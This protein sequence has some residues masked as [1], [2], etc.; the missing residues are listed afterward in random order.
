MRDAHWSL[1]PPHLFIILY[2]L[3]RA[4]LVSNLSTSG[5][6]TWR[7]STAVGKEKRHDKWRSAQYI[8]WGVRE[9]KGRGGGK[10]VDL[11][12]C[13]FLG[14]ASSPLSGLGFFIVTLL[15]SFPY[16]TVEHCNGG[17]QLARAN[18][19]SAGARRRGSHALPRLWGGVESRHR[20][21]SRTIVVLLFV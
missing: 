6:R 15:L 20:V 4:S 3:Q 10:D 14:R 18:P 11:L 19:S 1:D 21:S 5:A 7:A 16:P 2:S 17:R 12:F 13:V 9:G 8:R